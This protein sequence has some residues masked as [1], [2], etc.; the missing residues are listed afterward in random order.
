MKVLLL[1]LLLMVSALVTTAQDNPNTTHSQTFR[2]TVVD[3]ISQQA[4]IGAT[5]IVQGTTPIIVALTDA[6]GNFTLLNVPVGRQIL[7]IQYIG[8]APYI[9]DGIIVTTAKEPYLEVLMA[10]SIQ[11]TTEVVVKASSSN[12]V[13]NRALNELSVVSTRSFS[14]EQTQR[15]AGSIDDPSRMAMA[16]P[17]VQGDADD[18]NEIIIRGNSPMGMIW[19]L[20]GLDIEN[21]SH[22]INPGS[23]GGGISA[24][25]VAVLGQSDFSSGAFAAE[26]GNAFAGVFDLRFRK[27]NRQQYDFMARLGIIG[28]DL[29]AEGPI[30]KGKSSFLFNYRYSTLGILGAL[31]LYVVRENVFNDFQDLSFNLVFSSKDNKHHLKVFGLGGISS[32]QW[33]VKDSSDWQTSLDYLRKNFKTNMGIAGLNYTCLLDE[34]SYLN[35]VAGVQVYQVSDNIDDA[36]LAIDGLT[37]AAAVAEFVA[38]KNK[39]TRSFADYDAADSTR[40][41]TNEYLYGRYSLQLNRA[42]GTCNVLQP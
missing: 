9:S 18:E 5:V 21:S 33:M 28:I 38:K 6:D 30:K 17:G 24:L 31:G 16:F 37:S 10:E 11:M 8:Y 3:G 42:I 39:I 27:G 22:F 32:E 4:L 14:A 29:A 41:L 23:T 26:Y 7:E 19:R 35:V 1:G 36:S 15:Y 12:G 34:K 25:S 40:L 13:G 20:Q 2:G